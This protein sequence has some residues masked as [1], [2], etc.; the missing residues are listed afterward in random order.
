MAEGKKMHEKSGRAAYPDIIDHPHWQSPTRPHMSL[1]DR[2]AQF[3]PFAALVGY[4]EMVNEE[5][6]TV[7][8]RIEPGE[9]SLQRLNDKLAVISDRI[10]SGGCPALSVTYFVPDALKDGGSYGTVTGKAKKID[11]VRGVLLLA[12]A[13]GGAGGNLEIPLQD[14]LE[15]R[16]ECVD[17]LEGTGD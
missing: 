15:I 9:A 16:G 2:A 17:F 6:R 7:E 10:R 4:D 8:R 11:T 14:I 12:G 5:A 3:A 13:R 1:Y